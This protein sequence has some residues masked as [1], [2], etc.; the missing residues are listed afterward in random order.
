MVRKG[1][2]GAHTVS[3]EGRGGKVLLLEG[4]PGLEAREGLHPR[5]KGKCLMEMGLGLIR[6]LG[7]TCL[8]LP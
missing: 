8:L 6:A 4:W 7:V 3:H 5:P 2:A 1:G